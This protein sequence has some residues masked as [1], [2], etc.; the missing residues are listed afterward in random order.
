MGSLK[1]YNGSSWEDV[2]FKKWNGSSWVE[3]D[4]KK[5]DGSKWVI[6]NQQQ[7]TT[8]WEATWTQTYRE[9]GIKRTD[10]RSGKLCQGKYSGDSN[11][12]GIQRSLCGFNDSDMRSKLSG[13]KI[14]DVKLY[15]K[16]EHWYYNSGGTAYIGYHNHANE[17]TNYSHSKYNAKSQKF[18]S[19]DEAIWID[20][21]N[22]LGEGI[23][24]NDYKGISIFA[25]STSYNYYGVFR[26]ASDGSY[27]PKLKI[28]YTK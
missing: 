26:G 11:P 18:D 22:A 12:W 5:W 1:R 19:R 7:Y 10:S 16:A 14:N 3:P 8:T 23:R 21:P 24:D 28:T 20:M 4:V 15:L 6:L 17:P 27:K 25:N 2:P 9:S 13:A